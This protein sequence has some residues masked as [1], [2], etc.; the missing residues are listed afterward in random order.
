MEEFYKNN[1][2]FKRFVDRHC[3]LYGL[4]LEEALAQELVKQVY[5]YY[6]DLEDRGC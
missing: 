1:T 4:T 5:I 3:S 6:K 2:D